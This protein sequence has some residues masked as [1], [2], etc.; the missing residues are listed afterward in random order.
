[1]YKSSTISEIVRNDYRTAEV[2]KKWGINFCCGGN[3]S[4]A[5]TCSNKKLDKSTIEAELQQVSRDIRVPNSIN[6]DKWPIEF[7]IDYILNVHH[8]YLYTVIPQLQG[9]LESFVPGHKKKYPHIEKVQEAFE[10]IA[11]ELKEHMQKEELVVFP[12]IKQVS[13]TLKNKEVYGPLFVRLLK[14][15]LDDITVNDHLRI[16]ALVFQLR[17]ETI[18]YTFSEDACTRYQVIYRQLK[19]FDDDLVQ[20]KHLENNILFPKGLQLEKELLEL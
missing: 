1:M 13:S 3:L 5:E 7:L 19:E 14:K 2:F 6:Y 15:S 9:A 12:Y 17:K 18:N 16:E 8:A 11:V 4:L 10:D 20:H